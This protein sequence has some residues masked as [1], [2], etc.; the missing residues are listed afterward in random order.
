[1]KY[2]VHY[3]STECGESTGDEEGEPTAYSRYVKGLLMKV[4]DVLHF[5][6]AER[7]E[8]TGDE[9]GGTT[10]YYSECGEGIRDEEGAPTAYSHTA[11]T[12]K[13]I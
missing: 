12:P 5:K 2:V 4:Y 6:S 10:A 11:A 13:H 9:E 7:G 8:S 3:L 1:M